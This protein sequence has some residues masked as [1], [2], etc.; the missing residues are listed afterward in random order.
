MSKVVLRY[1]GALLTNAPTGII[2]RVTAAHWC[3]EA[4]V[5]AIRTLREAKGTKCRA[6][7]LVEDVNTVAPAVAARD[8]GRLAVQTHTEV[9]KVAELAHSS[10]RAAER[11]AHTHGHSAMDTSMDIGTPWGKPGSLERQNLVRGEL[12]LVKRG[13]LL[14]QGLDLVLK[15]DLHDVCHE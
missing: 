3:C 10:L 1:A 7:R 14:L 9:S 2:T 11:H 13:L 12:L 5:E 6:R 15:S 8:A 4:V